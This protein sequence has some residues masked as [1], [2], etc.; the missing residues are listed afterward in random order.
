MLKLLVLWTVDWL[1][2][3]WIK[4]ASSGRTAGRQLHPLARRSWWLVV[5]RL[6]AIAV[7]SA[8]P[9]R[10]SLD[11]RGIGFK[12]ADAVAGAQGMQKDAPQRVRAGVRHALSEC[13]AQGHC[14]LPRH[15]LVRAAVQVLE[16]SAFGRAP[17]SSCL[18]RCRR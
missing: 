14:G 9:F 7:V 6:Q 13:T 1:W 8:N 4:R 11:I 5:C 15:L 17:P 12:T 10:L 3:G 2:T 16:V 18:Q